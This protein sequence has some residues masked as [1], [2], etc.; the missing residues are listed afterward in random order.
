ME[1]KGYTPQIGDIVS[2]RRI[3]WR[4]PPDP[5]HI[6]GTVVVVDPC[7]FILSYESAS[8][9]C[10]F[11]VNCEEWTIQ[12]LGRADDRKGEPR[13]LPARQQL[14]LLVRDATQR[15]ADELLAREQAERDAL[16]REHDEF[17]SLFRDLCPNIAPLVEEWGMRTVGANYPRESFARVGVFVFS[18]ERWSDDEKVICIENDAGSRRVVYLVDDDTQEAE[19]NVLL[20]IAELD[21]DIP[22]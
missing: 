15:K 3:E 12:L 21:G 10:R 19:Y 17:R 22:F 13:V 2:A 7:R 4:Q 6:I 14:A 8:E 18:I 5:M 9:R 1:T 11:L 20:A 16:K